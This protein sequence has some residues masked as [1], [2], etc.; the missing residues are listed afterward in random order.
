MISNGSGFED[1]ERLNFTGYYGNSV[2]KGTPY[3]TAYEIG[4][5]Y[6]GYPE[7]VKRAEMTPGRAPQGPIYDAD[8]FRRRF[9]DGRMG[10]DPRL[11]SVEAGARIYRTALDGIKSDYKAFLAG[12]ESDDD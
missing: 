6:Y 11:A 1:Y 2:V 10:S 7:H 12:E 3:L 8:D 9:P 5:T 4:W